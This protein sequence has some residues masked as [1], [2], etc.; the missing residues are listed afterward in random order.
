MVGPD[1]HTAHPAQ[2]LGY[3]VVVVGAGNPVVQ[4]HRGMGAFVDPG[5]QIDFAQDPVAVDGQV[6]FQGIGQGGVTQFRFFQQIAG[7]NFH[8]RELPFRADFR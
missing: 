3:I 2:T 6:Q 5:G 4:N 1:H 7:I 8:G